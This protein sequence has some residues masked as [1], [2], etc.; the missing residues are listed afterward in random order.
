MTPNAGSAS[1][2]F[3]RCSACDHVR[4]DEVGLCPTCWSEDDETLALETLEGSVVSY[5]RIHPREGRPYWLLSIALDSG[6]RF[7]APIDGEAVPVIG[8]R[9]RLGPPG[10]DLAGACE[11]AAAWI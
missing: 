2:R 11:V 4:V 9:V 5:T 6:V 8:A 3:A 7:P 10:S 1:I